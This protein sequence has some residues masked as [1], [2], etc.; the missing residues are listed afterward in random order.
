MMTTQT[1]ETM[2]DAQADAM[3]GLDA[4]EAGDLKRARELL[5]GAP[6]TVGIGCDKYAGQITKVT[7]CVITVVYG[8]AQQERTFRK[9]AGWSMWNS[10]GCHFLSFG[11]AETYYDL[12]H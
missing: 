4:L 7:R 3:V 6:V 11:A 12:S 5:V 8:N 9:P 2:T 10:K 1:T